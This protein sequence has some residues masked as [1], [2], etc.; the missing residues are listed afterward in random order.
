MRLLLKDAEISELLSSISDSI[1]DRFR[2]AEVVCDNG[3]DD[4]DGDDPDNSSSVLGDRSN[5]TTRKSPFE[6]SS[7]T[8]P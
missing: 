3:D 1:V 8:S 4:D 2:E 6:S 7:K 5:L